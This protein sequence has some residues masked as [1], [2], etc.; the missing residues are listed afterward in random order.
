[1][2][3]RGRPLPC[4]DT[5]NKAN[6][7]A[8]PRRPL[9]I[10]F[11]VPAYWPAVA[12]GGPVWI[13]RDLAEALVARGHAVDV[14]TTTLRNLAGERVAPG[15]RELGGV[16]VHYVAPR[17]TSTALATDRVRAMNAEL[18]VAMDEPKTVGAA[19]VRALREERS[20]LLLGAPER[21]FA[22]LN[23]LFPALVDRSVRRQL[24]VIRRYASNAPAQ[25]IS[26]KTAIHNP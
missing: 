23:A 8:M 21:L 26:R 17:A 18:R 5:S 13:T 3:R 10:V 24:G 1:M 9:R 4:L 16:R 22:K 20:E 7:Y 12:Y 2:R 25:P 19:I 6:V 11:T 15:T 14:V